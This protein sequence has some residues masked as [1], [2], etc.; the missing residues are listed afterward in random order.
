[1]ALIQLLS[2]PPRQLTVRAQQQAQHSMHGRSVDA[3]AVGPIPAGE[4]LGLGESFLLPPEAPLYWPVPTMPA[5]AAA[6]WSGMP[7]RCVPVRAHPTPAQP[8]SNLD[9]DPTL[10]NIYSA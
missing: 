1:M 8:E 6:A 5:A 2:L 10:T 4:L 7:H 3:S 9:L